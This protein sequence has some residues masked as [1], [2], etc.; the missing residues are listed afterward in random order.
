MTFFPVAR[1]EQAFIMKVEDREKWI[2]LL[3]AGCEIGS[4]SYTHFKLGHR[5]NRG[6]LWALGMF[7]Q[8]LDEVLGFHYEV[9]WLRPP[10]GNIKDN[11]FNG[12]LCVHFLRD[13]EEAKANDP[14]YGV[15]NQE[16]IRALWKKISGEEIVN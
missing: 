3:D 2:D 6:V 12:H 13:M 16:T 8:T 5:D 15:S 1:T 10:Y 7:Q 14:N 9:R 4:H 11:D